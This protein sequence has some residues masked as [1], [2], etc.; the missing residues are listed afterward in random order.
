MTD[1]HV[2]SDERTTWRLYEGE[3]REPLAEHTNATD[4]TLDAQARAED[5]G[6]ERVVHDRYNRPHDIDASP[7]ERGERACRAH[8]YQPDP[9]AGQPARRHGRHD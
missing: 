1:L 6:V 7:D 4:A 9:A 5:A 2:V 3:Q 8:A